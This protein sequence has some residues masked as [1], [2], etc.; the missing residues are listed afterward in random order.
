MPR[1]SSTYRWQ[2]TV[3]IVLAILAVLSLI[4]TGILTT[5]P[6]PPTPTPAEFF[7]SGP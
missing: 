4:L 1:R 3:F 7:P 5:V 2:Q 6:P